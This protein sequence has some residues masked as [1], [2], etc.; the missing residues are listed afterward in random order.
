[1]SNNTKA[2]RIAFI[3]GGNMAQAL[4]LG[5]IGTELSARDVLVIDPNEQARARWQNAGVVAQAAI[6]GRLQDYD[7]WVLA[8]KPQL[9]ASVVRECR[10]YRQ[11]KTLVLSIAAGIR[12]TDIAQWLTHNQ[13][14]FERIIRCMPNTP[15]LVQQGV[16]GMMALDAVS[17]AERAFATQLMA[18]VGTVVWVE[19]DAALD[20]V[21]ALSG[22]GPAYVFL[23]LEALMAGGEALGLS[24]EQA[25]EL[26]LQTVLGA[27]QLAKHSDQPVTQLRHNVTS[28]GGTTAAALDVFQQQAF[29]A[30]V[31]EAM[32]AAAHRAKE[33]ADQFAR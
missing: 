18:T 24:A 8:V 29:S 25:R 21:T 2:P 4:G 6:D 32:R 33:L 17:E 16:T 13:H 11:D 28:E 27:A 3:G 15:A 22:S 31:T 5:L 20:A 1:M 19:D 9:L 10:A 12:A 30:I 7:M 23:F 26:A 14:P